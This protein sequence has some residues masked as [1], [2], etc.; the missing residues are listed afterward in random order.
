L[1][2]LCTEKQKRTIKRFEYSEAFEAVWA[3]YPK[4][5]GKAEAYKS[6]QAR[7][8]DSGFTE[9][10]LIDALR[11]YINE[12]MKKNTDTKYYLNMSSFFGANTQ[13]YN[14]YLKRSQTTPSSEPDWWPAAGK[15][16]RN[17]TQMER[18]IYNVPYP[19][20]VEL[21]YTKGFGR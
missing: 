5:V 16:I 18:G 17:M 7:V 14:D 12:Q 19:L 2:P 20:P 4:P 6:L 13:R 3:I 11:E 1:L 15:L 8:A 9:V 10:Q 21:D